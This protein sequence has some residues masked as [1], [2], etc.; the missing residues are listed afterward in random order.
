MQYFSAHTAIA[1][2]KFEANVNSIVIKHCLLTECPSRSILFYLIFKQTIVS[3]HI[4][5]VSKDPPI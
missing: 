3:V 1:N 5:Q 2:H 4:G